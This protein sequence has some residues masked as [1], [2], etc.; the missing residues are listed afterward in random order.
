M[1]EDQKSKDHTAIDYEARSMAQRALDRQTTHEKFC[2]ER[3]RRAEAFETDL[4]RSV[5][6]IHQK[7]DETEKTRADQRLIEAKD[8]AKMQT[9]QNIMWAG[10]TFVLVFGAKYFIGG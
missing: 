7:M 1:T 2:E 3:T 10:L 9:R 4:K 8:Q 6:R 5:A